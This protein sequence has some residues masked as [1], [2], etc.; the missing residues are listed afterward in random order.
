VLCVVLA[1][2]ALW[3]IPLAILAGIAS[4]RLLRTSFVLGEEEVM[5][6][7]VIRSHRLSLKDSRQVKTRGGGFLLLYSSCPALIVTTGDQPRTVRCVALAQVFSG[8][9]D[10]Y[11]HV[12]VIE[13][14][15][16]ESRPRASAASRR[17]EARV[18]TPTGD[19]RRVAPLC[20][21]YS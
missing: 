2:K 4:V 1:Y 20:H 9:E 19:V 6:G 10:L 21:Y 7:N 15:A 12:K 11:N 14:A 5:V 13:A 17:L 18:R 3:C 16:N 8:L